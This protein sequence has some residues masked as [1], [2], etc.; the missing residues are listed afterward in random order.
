MGTPGHIN[1]SPGP[2]TVHSSGSARCLRQLF[3]QG[4]YTFPKASVQAHAERVKVSSQLITVE[5]I[6][7]VIVVTY[8]VAEIAHALK[9]SGILQLTCLQIPC[10][11][12]LDESDMMLMPVEL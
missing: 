12:S 3:S 2:R 5:F 6:I 7:S 9:D 1:P 11:S 4:N 10:A 8:A